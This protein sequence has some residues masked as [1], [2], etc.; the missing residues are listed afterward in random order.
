MSKALQLLA[1]CH[2]RI[3]KNWCATIQTSPS[4]PLTAQHSLKRMLCCLQK[5]GLTGSTFWENKLERNWVEWFSGQNNNSPEQWDQVN[6]HRMQFHQCLLDLNQM[7]TNTC[8]WSRLH[9]GKRKQIATV[10]K[11][12]SWGHLTKLLHDQLCSSQ[13][14]KCSK[15]Y[16]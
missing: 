3:S 5:R 11:I 2:A 8:Q 15:Q 12:I 4:Y 14:Q 1:C 13:L 6:S 7:E 16:V 10:V 9:K